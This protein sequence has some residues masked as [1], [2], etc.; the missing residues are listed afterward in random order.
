ME[1]YL[2]AYQK[3]AT[4]S[5]GGEMN[6]LLSTAIIVSVIVGL[7]FVPFFVDINVM[8]KYGTFY[9]YVPENATA[10]SLVF[11]PFK[12]NR[13]NID[14]VTQNNS[15]LSIR[16]YNAREIEKYRGEYVELE[17]WYG[18]MD[19]ESG[20]TRYISSIKVQNDSMLGYYPRGFEHPS[21]YSGPSTLCAYISV[22]LISFLIFNAGI[23]IM[24]FVI[25]MFTKRSKE[26]K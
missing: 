12:E 24:F 14:V 20:Y 13:E 9:C 23:F 1:R 8:R 11:G 16:C 10:Y 7:L 3:L 5:I 4:Q 15:T 26:V 2:I 21:Y 17:V 6:K 19:D 22:V 18:V 25:S